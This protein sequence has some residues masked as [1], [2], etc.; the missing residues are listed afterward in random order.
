MR[1]AAGRV[2]VV[3]RSTIARDASRRSRCMDVCPVAYRKGARAVKFANRRNTMKI[4]ARIA[5]LG[6][7]AAGVI[8]SAMAQEKVVRIGVLMPISGPGSYIGVMGKEG[9]E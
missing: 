1:S 5:V 7:A 4:A 6:L 2:P 9:I 8:G 3:S